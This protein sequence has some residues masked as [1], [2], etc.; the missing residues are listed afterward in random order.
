MNAIGDVNWT[1]SDNDDRFREQAAC[2]DY[3]TNLFFL[4]QF[5]NQY[6]NKLSRAREVCGVC[7]VAEDC[8]RF[9]LN[10]HIQYGIWAGTTPLQRKAM[11]RRSA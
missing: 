6:H 5:E 10:N 8:L 1:L 7:P 3:P 4:E 2:R 11:R 9:A